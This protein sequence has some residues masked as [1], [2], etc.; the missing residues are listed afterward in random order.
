MHQ[1]SKVLF[2]PAIDLTNFSSG[3]I[4]QMTPFEERGTSAY[5]NS[6]KIK[7]IPWKRSLFSSL[8]LIPSKIIAGL[9]S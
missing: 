5:I 2:L 9:K 4:S 3:P 7:I 1:F 8:G 6:S